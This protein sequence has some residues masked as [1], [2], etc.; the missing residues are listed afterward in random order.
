MRNVFVLRVMAALA[1]FL[2]AG[3][4][5][6]P[7]V[8]ETL[9]YSVTVIAQADDAARV[10]IS[11]QFTGTS[12]GQTMIVLPASWGGEEALWT[13]LTD[14]QIIGGGGQV[15]DTDEPSVWR[16]THLPG[17]RLTL[18]YEIV[19]DWSGVPVATHGNSYR[20][21]LQP[22]YVHLIGKT[23]F[24]EP[25][26]PTSPDLSVSINTPADWVLTS[27]LEHGVV[28]TEALMG[29]I[30]VAGDFRVE[31]RQIDEAE[32]R[33]AVRGDWEF[34]DAEF[35]DTV[36]RVLEANHAYW[37]DPGEDF[38]VTVLPL[39]AEPD[40]Q[41]L[42]GTTL[43]D[44]FAFFGTVNMDPATL[45][46]MLTHEHAHTWNSARLGGLEDGLEEASGYWFSEGFTDFLT[47]RVGV[48]AGLW[49][50][51]A[52]IARWNEVLAELAGSPISNQP[53]SAIRENF[54]TDQNYQRLPYIRGMVFAAHA[55]SRIRAETNNRHTLDTVLLAMKSVAD[56]L[57]TAPS[58]FVGETLRVTGVDL[59]ADYQR[60]ILSGET[61]ILDVAAFGACGRVAS[62]EQ[63]VFGYGMTASNN[64]N[65]Q[66]QIESVDPDGPAARAGFQA[67]M[68]IVERLEGQHGDA[69]VDMVF[70]VSMDGE[71]RDLRY[72]PATGETLA[73]Q[74][75]L[76]AD[77]D[78]QTER[79]A[80]F[81]SGRPAH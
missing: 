40:W 56:D 67:G 32:L 15:Q 34:S 11:M 50:A 54:W 48:S 71:T 46:Q 37:G 4:S 14:P 44:A 74:Q 16:V 17:E 18:Q 73:M 78:L 3:C 69:G 28:D 29:S 39:Q 24:A 76:S 51:D 8:A 55:D 6:T 21:V 43:G 68:T 27:D 20:P 70:R 31:R 26:I 49:S 41:S 57:E 30:I 13:G 79:C 53:N 42:G 63:P 81:L 35:T 23:I 80:N 1:A 22:D 65:G 60:Y 61:I 64:D 9:D 10:L 77:G 5:L 62:I 33:V 36:L 52:S 58:A 75:I 45:V 38:L 12:E 2:L 66:L 19:Q 59:E 47:Q 72:R 25:D 7:R